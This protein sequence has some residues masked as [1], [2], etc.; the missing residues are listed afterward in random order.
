M[1]LE[2]GKSPNFATALENYDYARKVLK[3]MG[4]E[5]LL[6]P[7]S[8]LKRWFDLSDGEMSKNFTCWGGYP[9]G[10]SYEDLVKSLISRKW[11]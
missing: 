1:I 5:P 2:P 6:I 7:Q 4:H 8:T 10:S 3:I 9:K 11:S